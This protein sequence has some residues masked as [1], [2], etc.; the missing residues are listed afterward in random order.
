VASGNPCRPVTVP[1]H[2]IAE[3]FIAAHAGGEFSIRAVQFGSLLPVPCSGS[4][5]TYERQT[6]RWSRHE[7]RSF[8]PAAGCTWGAESA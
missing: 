2:P 3:S 1:N 7:E 5:C 6:S 8:S 4:L